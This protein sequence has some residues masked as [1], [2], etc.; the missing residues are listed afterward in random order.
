[1]RYAGK[2][3]QCSGGNLSTLRNENF[4]RGMARS[5]GSANQSDGISI[6]VR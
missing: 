6:I 3:T 5:R 4:T 1:M 2:V